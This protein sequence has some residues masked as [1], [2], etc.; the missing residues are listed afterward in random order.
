MLLRYELISTPLLSSYFRGFLNFFSFVVVGILTGHTRLTQLMD[1]A[2]EVDIGGLLE[3]V[4]LVSTRAPLWICLR[5]GR[6]FRPSP[7]R[8]CS[9]SSLPSLAAAKTL[10][11]RRKTAETRGFQT[12][13]DWGQAPET[14]LNW[15]CI[16]FHKSFLGGGAQWFGLFTKPPARCT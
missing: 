1:L 14:R 13:R 2:G 4:S 8:S 3:V 6:A 15:P 10:V 11:W 16:L 5:V 7:S 12:P 9:P